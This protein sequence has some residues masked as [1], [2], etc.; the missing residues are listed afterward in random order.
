MDQCLWYCH[1]VDI[2]SMFFDSYGIRRWYR[3]VI[4]CMSTRINL[5]QPSQVGTMQSLR[6]NHVAMTFHYKRDHQKIASF[7]TGT[8]HHT[9]LSWA[10]DSMVLCFWWVVDPTTI[11]CILVARGF[12]DCSSHTQQRRPHIRRSR[13][14]RCWCQRPPR[15]GASSS[16][17]KGH[18]VRC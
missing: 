8:T 17:R 3:S 1:P 14:G 6:N 12:L 16:L 10:T 9:R 4:C 13:P 11:G 18:R 15:F 7:P 2:D 5:G